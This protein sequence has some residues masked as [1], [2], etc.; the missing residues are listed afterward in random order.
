[1]N[2]PLLNKIA[3]FIETHP[4]QY[5]QGNWCGT[6]CCIA[7]HALVLGGMVSRKDIVDAGPDSYYVGDLEV[8]D[9]AAELL[10]LASNQTYE[11]FAGNWMGQLFELPTRE[12]RAAAAAKLIRQFIRTGKVPT[13]I[14]APR[15]VAAKPARAGA[16][17]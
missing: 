9:T 15:K 17:P 12:A 5:N 10:G 6:A 13:R 3:T 14:S 11:L 7:G 4:R 2:K 1:V 8:Q 16:K